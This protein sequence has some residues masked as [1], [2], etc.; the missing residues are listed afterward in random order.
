MSAFGAWEHLMLQGLLDAF[1]I[2]AHNELSIHLES[3]N[4]HDFMGH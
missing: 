3:G 4:A 2:K 1:R